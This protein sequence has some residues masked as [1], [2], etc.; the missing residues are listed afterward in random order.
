[1]GEEASLSRVDMSLSWIEIVAQYIRALWPVWVVYTGQKGVLYRFGEAKKVLGP[2]A[3]FVF[4]GLNRLRIE[5]VAV[6]SLNLPTQSETTLDG[7]EVAYSVNIIYEVVD[8]LK[9]QTKV[10]DFNDTLQ[11]LIMVHLSRVVRGTN[12]ADILAHRGIIESKMRKHLYRFA[13]AWG[14]RILELGLTDFV[15]PKHL[16]HMGDIVLNNA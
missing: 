3:Y 8:P 11:N 12:Y 2:G 9:K 1:M 7:Y 6:D 14:V 16:R 5:P 10:Q 4:W 13:R 15:R